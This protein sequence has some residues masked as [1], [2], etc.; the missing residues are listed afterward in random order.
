MLDEGEVSPVELPVSVAVLFTEGRSER[1][2]ESAAT[3]PQFRRSRG[4]RTS[5]AG[6]PVSVTVTLTDDRAETLHSADSVQ[7]D[8]MGSAV[9]PLNPSC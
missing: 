1:G 5:L 9:A 7:G 8:G 6:P 3:K 2:M 4:F